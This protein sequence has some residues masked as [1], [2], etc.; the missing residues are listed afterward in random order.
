MTK[1]LVDHQVLSAA[2]RFGTPGYRQARRWM[3]DLWK[4]RTGVVSASTLLV[5]AINCSLPGPQV[6][7]DLETLLAWN[8]LPLD[9][10]LIRDAISFATHHHLG[11]LEALRYVEARRLGANRYLGPGGSQRPGFQELIGLDFRVPPFGKAGSLKV[12]PWGAAA[13]PAPR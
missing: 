1:I 5:F 4:E 3:E 7:H 13:P 2:R 8:P 11:F 12:T 10:G 9:E 6:L